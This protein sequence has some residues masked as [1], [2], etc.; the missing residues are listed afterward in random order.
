[1]EELRYATSNQTVLLG[2]F[3]SKT[4]G[5]QRVPYSGLLL[6]WCYWRYL[7]KADGTVVDIINRGWAEVPNCDGLYFLTLLSSDLNQK[8]VL[9]IYIHDDAFLGKPVFKQ[10]MVIDENIYDAKYGVKLLRVEPEAQEF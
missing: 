5:C 3:L 2:V 10:F 6:D 1:M 9:T 7:I 8:G 4:K